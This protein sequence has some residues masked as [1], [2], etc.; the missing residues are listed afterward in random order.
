MAMRRDY[1]RDGVSRK[2]YMAFVLAVQ[3]PC[4][5]ST[6]FMYSEYKAHVL[7]TSAMVGAVE[8]APKHSWKKR[9]SS[10]VMAAINTRKMT[11][12]DLPLKAQELV[13]E[14]ILKHSSELQ[15]M[16][17]NQEI[18]KLPPL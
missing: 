10:A 2:Q 12:G 14:W 15:K 1:W 3:R 5:K 17:D 11:T 8:A 13:E 9:D 6:T 4:T 18:H 7:L 16:W